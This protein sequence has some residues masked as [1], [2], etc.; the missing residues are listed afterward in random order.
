MMRKTNQTSG[1]RPRR[2]DG[3]RFHPRRKVCGFCVERIR[4]IDYKDVSRLRRYISV[5]ANVEPRRKTGTCAPHQRA[6]SVAI[7]RARYVA[8]LPYTGDHS[9]IEIGPPDRGRSDRRYDRRGGRPDYSQR[10]P[11]APRRSEDAVE[12]NVANANGSDQSGEAKATKVAEPQGI[13]VPS[14]D[15]DAKE[16]AVKGIDE[17][18]P[19]ALEIAEVENSDSSPVR[20]D[21]Q[22]SSNEAAHEG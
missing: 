12:T 13:E 9:L 17:A 2:R 18:E 5:F 1:P 8:L 7:K 16:E 21:G 14:A 15:G 11:D 20:E 4:D 22:S 3:R 6:L 10:A 19:A